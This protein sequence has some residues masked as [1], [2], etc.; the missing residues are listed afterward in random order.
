MICKTEIVPKPEECRGCSGHA[1]PENMKVSGKKQ[2]ES[3][4]RKKRFNAK[5]RL[6]L[7]C[8]AV[9]FWCCQRGMS[10]QEHLFCNAENRLAIGTLTGPTHF[11][12]EMFH[13]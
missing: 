1:D 4:G 10:R 2:G 13:D 12:R 11:T 8:S 7:G 9:G 6:F 5:M 3:A